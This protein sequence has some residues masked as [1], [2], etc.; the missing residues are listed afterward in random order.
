MYQQ[1]SDGKC[2]SMNEQ[3]SGLTT[4][5]T[6]IQSTEHEPPNRPGNPAFEV[7]DRHVHLESHSNQCITDGGDDYSGNEDS[8][9]KVLHSGTLYTYKFNAECTGLSYYDYFK[10]PKSAERSA[11][12]YRCS[13]GPDAVHVEEG[14]E[15]T[16]HT[17]GSIHGAGFVI[18][19]VADDANPITHRIQRDFPSQA[20]AAFEVTS[21]VDDIHHI[22][23][24]K[25]SNQCF[26]DGNNKYSNDEEGTLGVMKKGILRVLEFATECGSD[27]DTLTINGEVYQ[28]DENTPDG[29]EV[30]VGDKIA[31][32]S[33]V[34]VTDVGYTI[35]LE[36]ITP[37]A[38]A[39]L[40]EAC[41]SPYQCSEGSRVFGEPCPDGK[42]YYGWKCSAFSSPNT[43]LGDPQNVNTCAKVKA[44][45]DNACACPVITTTDQAAG[46]SVTS[47]QV[48]D[49]TLC[50]DW[51]CDTWC[52]CFS[53]GDEQSGLYR[54][55]G[56]DDDD[57]SD[58]V[59]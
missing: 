44:F 11:Q 33:D 37:V 15:L 3:S 57:E 21:G 2:W 7:D 45:V 27:Y 25:A 58:C 17:D 47:T 49:P 36:V 39:V 43:C 42:E 38:T 16:W 48:C 26:T 5:H 30:N 46:D 23:L 6:H 8:T 54:D 59:C 41:E 10:I 50:A 4:C 32:K 29:V 40:M 13:S 53:V 18:C 52:R 34:S 28:C 12:K 1:D 24:T 22:H 55:N 19:M 51:D 31:W 9:I 14:E 56:C 20:D 35:C